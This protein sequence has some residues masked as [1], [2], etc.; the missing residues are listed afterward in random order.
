[1]SHQ[2]IIA[3]IDKIVEIPG[4][5]NIAQ[6]F[7]LGTPLIVSKE[8][9]EGD[10]G[11]LFPSELRLSE[12]YCSNNN[13]FRHS[14]LNKD[15]TKSGFFE[16]SRRVR[17]QPFM[18]I[19]SDGYFA[20]IDSL[21]YLKYDLTKLKVGD[22]FN[23]LGGKTVCEKYISLQTLNYLNRK[24]G[25]LK[26]IKVV[27]APLF[28]EHK[29][30]EQFRYYSH[31]IPPGALITIFSKSH[32]TSGRVTHTKI[33]K[34][35]P[36]WKKQINKVLPLFQSE[37]WDYLPGSRRCV[38]FPDKDS[39]KMGF[40]G[41]E[42]YRWDIL[43]SFK[44]FL[45]K[46]MTVYFEILGFVNGGLI[47]PKHDVTKLKNKKFVEKYGKEMVYK[48]NCEPHQYK[49]KVY[50]IS[51]ITES[52]ESIDFTQP[53]LEEWCDKRNLWA[54]KPIVP[55]FIYDGNLEKLSELVEKL[56]ENEENLCEDYIDKD[57]ILEGVIVRAD[58]KD[59]V[60][61]F[62]KQKSYSF[63]FM[64]GIIREDTIDSED[65]S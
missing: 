13:L 3:K 22:M 45:S 1:M 7:V 51:L 46:G 25:Q 15:N 23:E 12:D 32:G 39:G 33:I 47:M 34:T 26:K 35:L 65:A 52:G 53:Q 31:A 2:A 29:D 43:E 4:A 28:R 6:A 48:Y 5:L 62:L 11:I 57:C 63:K 19:K 49:V 27:E 41:S 30:T 44:P 59:T 50:R 54:A 8:S 56:A 60:P 14:H 36:W 17:C 40:H 42:Q 18:K 16:D 24:N 10:V 58:Y 64:E 9:K 55:P 61:L 21:Y 20:P 37:Y 38:L